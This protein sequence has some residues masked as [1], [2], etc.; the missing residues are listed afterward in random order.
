MRIKEYSRYN[1]YRV[2]PIQKSEDYSDRHGSEPRVPPKK[3]Y[4]PVKRLF[5]ERE[6]IQPVGVGVFLSRWA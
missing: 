4:A 2:Q 1:P 5:R 6:V 3:E